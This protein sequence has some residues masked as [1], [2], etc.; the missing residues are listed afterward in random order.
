MNLVIKLLNSDRIR[1]VLLES[2]ESQRAIEKLTDEILSHY[3]KI[4]TSTLSTS[5]FKGKGEMWKQVSKNFNLFISYIDLSD[6]KKVDPILKEFVDFG[7]TVRVLLKKDRAGQQGS[8]K[9]ELELGKL[10]RTIDLIYDLRE[11]EGIIINFENN[12]VSRSDLKKVLDSQKGTLVHELIHAYDDFVSLG[13]ALDDKVSSQTSSYMGY[14]KKPSEINARYA[15]TVSIIKELKLIPTSHSRRG[16]FKKYVDT[17]K[18]TFTGWQ[19]MD[20]KIQKRLIGR[21]AKEYESLTPDES[22]QLISSALISGFWHMA[23][24]DKPDYRKIKLYDKRVKINPKK[25]MK[26]LVIAF[27]KGK[28]PNSNTVY[29][30]LSNALVDIYEGGNEEI[31]A[32]EFD[33]SYKDLVTIK[34]RL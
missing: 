23:F 3:S 19:E 15:E 31:M 11:W 7:I 2:I 26:K 25:E 14:L 27:M 9:R 24:S 13:K 1:D 16:G 29:D 17:F 21:L 10:F 8:Y 32:K 22:K 30:G 28:L 5:K 20:K 6:I 33:L 34:R 18:F 4:L 12:V